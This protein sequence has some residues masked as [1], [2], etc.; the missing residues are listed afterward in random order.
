[1]SVRVM[2]VGG[3]LSG[4]GAAADGRGYSATRWRLKSKV[5]VP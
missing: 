3:G 1:M 4:G 5:P 2:E